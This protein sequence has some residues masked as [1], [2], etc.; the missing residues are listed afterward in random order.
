MGRIL[1]SGLRLLLYF[2]T[3]PSI[4][5]FLILGEV[6]AFV[7]VVYF[8]VVVVVENPNSYSHIDYSVHLVFDLQMKLNLA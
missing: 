8:V 1:S 6:I 4:S 7:A 5:V 2:H 3:E